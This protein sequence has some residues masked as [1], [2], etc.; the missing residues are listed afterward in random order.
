MTPLWCNLRKLLEGAFWKQ[1]QIPPSLTVSA[2]PKTGQI[3]IQMGR[4]GHSAK[5]SGQLA[6]LVFQAKAAGNARLE[7]QRPSFIRADKQPVP[8][9]TQH[10]RISVH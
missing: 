8:V 10:G 9:I 3:V 1:N 6:T 7:I 5:G 4:T 2:V